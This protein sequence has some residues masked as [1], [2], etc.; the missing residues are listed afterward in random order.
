V[1]EVTTSRARH[2]LRPRSTP[3]WLSAQ[4]LESLVAQ[5]TYALE[6]VIEQL[7][8]KQAELEALANHDSLTGLATRRR[9]KDRFQCAVARAK[10]D[11]ASFAV[12]VIDLTVSSASTI[13]MGMPLE[14]LCWSKWHGGSLSRCVP[15]TRPRGWG[16]MNSS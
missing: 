14:T 2:H 1:L 8:A 16:E 9:L 11:S 15:P 10:R 3:A 12:L 13:P 7:R 5:R 4:R 6:Q